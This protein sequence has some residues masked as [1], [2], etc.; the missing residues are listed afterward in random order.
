MAYVD[1]VAL[2]VY[3][4]ARTG[5]SVTE[6]LVAAAAAGNGNKFFNDGKTFVRIKNASASPIT[7]TINTP[8]TVYGQALAD[9]TV[10]IAATGDG[11]GLDFQ[12]IGP[13]TTTF[14]QSDGYV[15]VDTSLATSIT[16][17]AYRL[18]NP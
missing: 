15:W 2:V 4:I 6:Q 12:D 17:G 18:A 3:D 14:N 7:V 5:R 11:D 9:L 13:F 1:A 8:G 10:T 16:I